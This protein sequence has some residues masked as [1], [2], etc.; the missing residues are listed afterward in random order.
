MILSVHKLVTKNLLPPFES[1]KLRQKPVVV[2]NLKTAQIVFIPPDYD[3]VESL[4]KDLIVFINSNQ[5]KID[6]LILASI[7]HKQMAIIHPFMDGNGRT[8]RLITK[9]LSQQN[10]ITDKNY[11]KL[12]SRAK[13][14]RA[15]DFQKLLK[16]GLIKRKGRGK[17][18]YYIRL[19]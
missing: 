6:P 17:N 16:L 1:G 19:E 15:L 3:Q 4:M 2:N 12:T 18:T 9:F 13:A 7:F 14:T 10:F 8:A 5:K 11:A